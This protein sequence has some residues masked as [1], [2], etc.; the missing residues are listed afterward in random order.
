MRIL[1]SGRPAYGH[2]YPLLP[3]ARAARDAGHRVTIATGP[4]FVPQ[5]AEFGFDTRE[6]GTSIGVAEAE[7]VQRHPDGPVVAV[8]ATMFADILA[9][10]TLADLEPMLKVDRPDLVIYEMSDVGAAGAA[11]RA[12][13]PAVSVTIGRS[14]PTEARGFAA[15]SFE[16]IWDGD[17]PADPMLGDA[18]LDLWPAGLAD[19][20][21]AAVPA[22]FPLRPVPWSAPAPP[23]SPPGRPLVY[24]TLGTVSFHVIEVFRAALDGLARLPVRVVVAT[25][26]GD[27]AALGPVASNVQVA[28]FVPQARVLAEADLVV[29]HGGS[30]TTLG[31]AAHG[32]P[33]LVLPQGAD[34]FVNADALAAQGS[35]LGL[36]GDDV[37]PDVI[38][39][40]AR[41]LLGEPVHRATAQALAAQIA[42]MPSPA[43]VLPELEA[44]A[45]R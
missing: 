9:R 12:G 14:M 32:L 31:A 30:G 1:F 37:T 2:L 35:G 29:H 5:L 22:R 34:Q 42:A 18:C 4:T 13:I 6:A 24:L 36:T 45:A 23:W 41:T 21:A 33:Q 38:A 40:C 28:R 39:E 11:R 27:P 17:V 20:V 15:P 43:Q 7:A 19:P 44:F 26:P 10:R 8:M 25:G 3:L 16:W